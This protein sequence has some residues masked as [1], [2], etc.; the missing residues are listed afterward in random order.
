MKVFGTDYDGVIINIE[1]QKANAVPIGVLTNHAE[2]ELKTAGAK[3]T[4]AL[5]NAI[6]TIK[7]LM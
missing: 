3:A 4:C 6:P 1:P 7:K 5:Q 2:Q